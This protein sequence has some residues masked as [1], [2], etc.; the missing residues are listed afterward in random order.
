M[1]QLFKV[2]TIAAVLISV[3][4]CTSEQRDTVDSAAG[5]AEDALRTTLSVIDIDMGRHA[6]SDKK[7]TD[8]TDDFAPTD[9][10]FASV[11]MSGT[12]REG[13]V[14]GRWT[15]PDSSIVEQKAD[16]VTQGDAYL[17]FFVAKPGGLTKGKYT[18]RVFVDGQEVRSKDVTVM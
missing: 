11:H 13:Q 14:V 6:G 4:A 17:A 10:I 3:A 16:T 7:I 1:P 18:F 12:S 2:T 9:T 15:F 5:T 8:K